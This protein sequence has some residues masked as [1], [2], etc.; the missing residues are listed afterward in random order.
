[1]SVD[2]TRPEE[3]LLSQAFIHVD[4]SILYRGHIT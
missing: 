4:C 2:R 1:V 3:Y